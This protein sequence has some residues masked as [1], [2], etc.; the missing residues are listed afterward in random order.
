MLELAGK[1]LSEIAKAQIMAMVILLGKHWVLSLNFCMH[2]SWKYAD[3]SYNSITG[4]SIMFLSLES[5]IFETQSSWKQS[6]S[7]CSPLQLSSE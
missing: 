7:F 4:L 5:Q 3:F 2:D 1:Y 6:Y